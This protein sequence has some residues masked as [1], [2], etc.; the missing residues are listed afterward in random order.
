[1]EKPLGPLCNRHIVKQTTTPPSVSTIRSLYVRF[2][3]Y[4]RKN[5]SSIH[6]SIREEGRVIGVW[7]IDCRDLVDNAYR[8]FLFKEPIEISFYPPTWEIEIICTSSNV[9][10]GVA[11]FY[12]DED[13][14]ST[15]SVGPKKIHGSISFDYD[16]TR[17]AARFEE[18]NHVGHI[19]LISVIVPSYNCSKY[20]KKCLISVLEQTYNFVEIVVVDD[21]S[22]EEETQ[23]TKYI[24]ENLKFVYE[25]E[26]KLTEHQTNKGASAARNT[27]AKEANGEFIFFLDSD[28]VLR[29]DAFEIMLD[30]LHN[31]PECSYSYCR[32]KWGDKIILSSPF[33]PEGL[34]RGNFVSMMSMLRRIDFPEDGLDESLSRYQDWELWLRLLKD[35]KG[36]VWIEDCLFESEKRENTISSGG[37]IS[38]KEA[39]GILALRHPWA[40]IPIF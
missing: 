15:F 35:K 6:V 34:K 7:R 1:M 38:D 23:E 8:E 14:K 17:E 4:C 25:R 31:R 13:E 11:L 18:Y 5:E 24:I 21:G 36:G 3:T 27:G 26:I 30:T 40:N 28:T 37:S 39:R 22:K 9:L 2:G 16:C 19:G 20:I 33:R 29:N 12:D 10:N 32:F